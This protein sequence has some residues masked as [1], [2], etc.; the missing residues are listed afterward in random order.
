MSKQRVC[1]ANELSQLISFLF[2][3]SWAL[4]KGVSAE[5]HCMQVR[6][7]F[8]SATDLLTPLCANA[9]QSA[10]HITHSLLYPGQL[11]K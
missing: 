7:G 10:E 4:I 8:G 3:A 1:I 6:K 9:D 5:L 11:Q 2:A